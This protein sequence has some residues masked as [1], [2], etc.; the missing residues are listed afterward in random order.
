MTKYKMPRGWRRAAG[1]AMVGT[2]IAGGLL[3]SGSTPTLARSVPAGTVARAAVPSGTGYWLANSE[4]DVYPF[5]GAVSYGSMAGNHLNAPIVG[6]VAAPD[7]EGLLAG[8]QRRRRVRLRF[9]PVLRLPTRYTYDEQVGSRDGNCPRSQLGRRR[10]HSRADRACWSC[11]A[12]R[13]Y[14][15]N[16]P[17]WVW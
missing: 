3:L 10:R 13:C 11:W 14:R 7:G 17:G 15:A 16:R 6:I 5:G 2:A 1:G 4:G 9:R 12:S 8:G